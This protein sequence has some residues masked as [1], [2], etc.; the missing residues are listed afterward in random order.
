MSLKPRIGDVLWFKIAPGEIR[1]LLVVQAWSPTCVSGE[2]TLLAN[3]VY[4]G[5][6]L[7]TGPN[8]AALAS[9]ELG[10]DVFQWLPRD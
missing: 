8:K 9:V 1:P 3:D 5:P 6:G 10:E 2:L 7:I 4:K